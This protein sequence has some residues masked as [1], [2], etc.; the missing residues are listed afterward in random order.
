MYIVLLDSFLPSCVARGTHQLLVLSQGSYGL[1]QDG[2][3]VTVRSSY[4]LSEGFGTDKVFFGATT[5]PEGL[6]LSHWFFQG[7]GRITTRRRRVLVGCFLR[8]T[9]AAAATARVMSCCGSTCLATRFTGTSLSM[10][11]TLQGQ[12]FLEGNAIFIIIFFFF[13]GSRL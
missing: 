13:S 4:W 1:G 8:S 12:G 10:P 5:P 3:F 9:C 7:L 2:Q 11:S 6:F